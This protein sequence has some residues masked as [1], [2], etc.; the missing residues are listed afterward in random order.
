MNPMV[1]GSAEAIIRPAREEDLPAALAV[2][3]ADEVRGEPDLPPLSG[4]PAVL[5]HIWRTGTM[6]VAEREGRIVAFAAAV[7]RDRP[8]RDAETPDRV[9]FLTDLFVHP[10]EQSSHLGTKLL[11]RA[12]PAEDGIRCTASSDDPRALSLYIRAGM[13]PQWPNFSLRAI[14][15]Q[16]HALPPLDVAV[17]EARPDDG[18]LVRWDAEIGGRH[19]PVDHAFWA[20]AERGVPMWLRRGKETIGYA[21][22]RLG[23]GTLRYPDA[24]YIG[25]V[26]ARTPDQAQDCVLAAVTWARRHAPVVLLDVPGPH[27]ALAP[28]LDARFRITYFDTFVSTADPPFFDARCYV[29][30]GGSLF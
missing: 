26:G 3:Y 8:G 29:G 4:V 13:Q 18:E 30:S 24:C 6:Y 25:P 9:A 1:D 12:M 19:R 27:P 11:Q 15:T 16:L 14:S 7:T 23:A 5:G 20:G 17:D 2:W 28:L 21:Y 22:A 10:D